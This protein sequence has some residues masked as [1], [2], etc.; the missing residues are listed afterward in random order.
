MQEIYQAAIQRLRHIWVAS[1]SRCAV[2]YRIV[3]S[4]NCRSG[5][6]T[7]STR[8][9]SAGAGHTQNIGRAPG[10]RRAVRAG[11]GR[12]GRGSQTADLAGA[13]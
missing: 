2:F 13:E 5:Q 6:P 1:G 3:W 7:R 9:T 12:S 10:L 4:E 11:E 8:R